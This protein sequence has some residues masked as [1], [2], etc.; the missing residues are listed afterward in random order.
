MLLDGARGQIE[1]LANFAQ[2]DRPGA[3]ECRSQNLALSQEVR[4]ARVAGLS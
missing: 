3:E 2:A 4:H 1:M